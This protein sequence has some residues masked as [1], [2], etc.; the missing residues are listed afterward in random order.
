MTPFSL[1]V[2]PVG[3]RCNLACDYCFY[4]G[5]ASLYPNGP[6]KMSDA[7]LERMIESY[8]SLPFDSF[9]I[10]FQ[11]GEPMLAG[12]DFFRR[13]ND[14][15]KRVLPDG[16]RLSLSIQTNAT[17]VTREAAKFFAGEGWLVGAS[18]DGPAKI[19][20]AHRTTP[21]GRGTH[22]EVLRGIDA[23]REAGCDYNVLTLVT[24][25]N[26]DEPKKIYR[27]VRDELGGK[28]QQYTDHLESISTQQWDAFLCG[29]LDAWLED[30]DM[31]RVSVRNIDA[32]LSYATFGR[33][34]QCLFAGRCDGH[35]VVERNGDV[36]PCDFFVTKETLLGNIMD[37]DWGELRESRIAQDFAAK[38][39]V[40]HLSKI[41]RMEFYDRISDL[42][43][44]GI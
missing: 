32:A 26:V 2:K 3:A 5:K 28:W 4:L 37:C 9:S 7:V 25:S 44:A 27:Y 10:A 38:K 11:G 6:A 22:A 30:G 21:D 42:A 43:A 12:L 18:V 8:L 16:L 41:D 39:C 15:A 24:N 1:L 36:Y 40:R 19:H 13:A 17:L 23:L 33:A 14:F 20:D 31:G 35:V 29:V 34:E